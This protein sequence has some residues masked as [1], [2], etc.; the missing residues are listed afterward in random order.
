[1]QQTCAH[2]S[3]AQARARAR[4]RAH[5]RAHTYAGTKQIAELEA[6][7]EANAVTIQQLQAQVCAH[8]QHARGA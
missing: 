7:G 3:I 6:L 2:V 5:A 4:K 8:T 1:M